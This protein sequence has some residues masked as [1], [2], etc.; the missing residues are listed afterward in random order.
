MSTPYDDQTTASAVTQPE[1]QQAQ[2]QLAEAAEKTVFDLTS[3]IGY[4]SEYCTAWKLAYGLEYNGVEV[5]TNTPQGLRQYSDDYLKYIRDNITKFKGT[6]AKVEQEIQRAEDASEVLAKKIWDEIVTAHDLKLIEVNIDLTGKVAAGEGKEDVLITIR[7]KSEQEVIELIKASLKTYKTSSGV[8]VYNS[9]FASYLVTLVTNKED[10]G[11]GKKAIAAFVN[12]HPEFAQDIESVLAVTSKWT[13]IKN[14]AKKAGDVDYREK[15]NQYITQNRGYQQMRDLLFKKIFT[16]FYERDKEAINERVLKRL[17]LDGADDIYAVIGTEK[18][19]MV[20][21]S[22]RTSPEFK[23]FYDNLKRGF[24]V[25]YDIP[26]NP[27]IVSCMLVLVDQDG[28]DIAKFNIGFKE[29]STFPHM[30]NM[31]SLVKAAREQ[32]A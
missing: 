17:G 3:I 29:G 5:K 30:W 27:D 16:Y 8:N 10:V 1:E 21:I 23:K 2:P 25:R 20:A 4:Y 18:S 7:K 14:A 26:D 15:A 19:R 13:E 9:T 32:N 12:D 6:A 24:T 28:E 31:T 22:S 11:N